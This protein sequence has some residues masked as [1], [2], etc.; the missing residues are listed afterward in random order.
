[1]LLCM[2]TTV[3]LNDQLYKQAKHL[4]AERHQTLTA[5]LEEGLRY[6][7]QRKSSEK[8]RKP[9]KIITF[10]G[11]GLMPGVDLDDNSALADLMDEGLDADHRR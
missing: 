3:D 2:R 4:A 5:V 6:L 1:M 7:I 8:S 10:N 9:F 11:D